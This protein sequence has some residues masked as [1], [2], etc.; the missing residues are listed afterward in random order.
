MTN[1]D[2]DDAAQQ[3]IAGAIA[4]SHSEGNFEKDDRDG[5]LGALDLKDRE[6]EEI[7]LDRKSVV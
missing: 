2:E 3:E 6:V 4:L 5:L 7:M 1:L